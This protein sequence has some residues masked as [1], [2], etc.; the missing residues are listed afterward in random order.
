MSQD[1][2]QTDDSIG[3]LVAPMIYANP[4]PKR[5]RSFPTGIFL[6]GIAALLAL[7]LIAVLTGTIH[8]NND[9]LGRTDVLG[10][11]KHDGTWSYYHNRDF[12]SATNGVKWETDR[13]RSSD[14]DEAVLENTTRWDY[15]GPY[16]YGPYGNAGMKRRA[17]GQTSAD[18]LYSQPAPLQDVFSLY[19]RDLDPSG[20]KPVGSA[21]S[22]MTNPYYDPYAGYSNPYA[23][24]IRIAYGEGVGRGASYA[25]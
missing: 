24:R 14:P 10:G 8:F 11:T 16:R 7:A 6:A 22:S 21:P 1:I 25:P 17:L 9:S 20:G 5:R 13:S 15:D 4:V 19:G 23:N 12:S 3:A 2:I 18:P